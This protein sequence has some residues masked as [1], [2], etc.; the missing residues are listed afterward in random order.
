MALD[1][2]FTTDDLEHLHRR[3]FIG[4]FFGIPVILKF[5]DVQVINHKFDLTL[6]DQNVDNSAIVIYCLDSRV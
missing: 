1:F 3:N 4:L 6:M 5:Q 2:K